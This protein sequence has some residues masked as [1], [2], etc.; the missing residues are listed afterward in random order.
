MLSLG[1][2]PEALTA[3]KSGL[4]GS[5]ARIVVH[6]TP[7]ERLLLWRQKLGEVGDRKI[8]SDWAY[9]LRHVTETL[10]LDWYEHVNEGS[11]V[12][13]RG[14]VVV[15]KQYPFM[16]C[17]L[18]GYVRPLNV[19]INCKHLS[20]W[21]K[22]AREWCIEHYTTQAT[23]EAIVLKADYALLSLLHGEKEPEI[24]RIDCDPFYAEHVIAREAEFWQCCADRVPPP[25]C[26]E[27]ATPK[28]AIE[29]SKLRIVQLD[30][31]FRDTWPNWAV[32]MNTL[33]G[34]FQHTYAAATAHAIT[35]DKI[36]SLLPEDVGTVTRENVTISRSKAN[37]VTIALK[38]GKTDE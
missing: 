21:T 15:S 13:R 9:A 32:E 1:L 29:V 24:I 12:D 18:D 4:G 25:D 27:L 5:D 16:R 28:A 23:H 6:G 3:R 37:A 20:K 14:E 26:A 10:Q 11:T 22:E 38:K 8:M 33:I 19:P 17:T 7:E 35:R 31:P 36:K 34:D 2:S 30:E